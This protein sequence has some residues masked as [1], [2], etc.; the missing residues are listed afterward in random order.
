LLDRNYPRA[1]QVTLVCDNLNTQGTTSLYMTFDAPT[2]HRLAKWLRIEH[3]PHNGS[4]LNMAEM[5]LSVLTRQCIGRRFDSND[6]MQ[7][8]MKQ[9][10][11][12][13]NRETPGPLGVAKKM[14]AKL[15]PFSGQPTTELRAFQL[16][17]LITAF[18]E[19]GA[20]EQ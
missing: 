10:Q 15:L 13:R 19:H 9:W 6:Q 11:R 17:P 3:T 16:I 1:K 14:H 4:W 2:A 8:S 5:E 20:T 18:T 12:D 7:R